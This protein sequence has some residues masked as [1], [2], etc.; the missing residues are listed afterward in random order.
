MLSIRSQQQLMEYFQDY[1]HVLGH[2]IW[3]EEFIQVLSH[4]IELECN[5]YL[6]RRIQDLKSTFLDIKDLS[7]VATFIGRLLQ[8]ILRLT[9]PSQS[10]YLAPMSGW[11]DAGGKEMFGLRPFRLLESWTFRDDWY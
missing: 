8:Q 10:M 5:A 9:D 6:K 11:F 1:G 4:N 2:K 3:Q 7:S